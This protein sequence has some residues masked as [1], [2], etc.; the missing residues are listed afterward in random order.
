MKTD[1]VDMI[2]NEKKSESMASDFLAANP[3]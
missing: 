3:I 2:A 1:D